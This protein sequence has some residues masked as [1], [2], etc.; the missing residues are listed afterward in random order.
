MK[1]RKACRHRYSSIFTQ[2]PLSDGQVCFKVSVT[3]QKAFQLLVSK[4]CDLAEE[5]GSDLT[6]SWTPKAEL[7]FGASGL[8]KLKLMVIVVVARRL[9]AWLCPKC[10]RSVETNCVANSD[11]SPPIELTN[12]CFRP[13][14][15]LS[16]LRQARH[17]F[18]K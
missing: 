17:V 1:C 12:E 13:A 9:T 10:R 6:S 2:A 15:L 5:N 8:G 3:A 11:H 14:K 18:S 16:R 4:K 7:C